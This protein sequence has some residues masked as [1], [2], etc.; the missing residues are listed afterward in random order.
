M[1]EKILIVVGDGGE[2]YETWFAR[3]RFEEAGYQ[4]VAA[5]SKRR[6]NLVIHD[7]EP[8]WD[9]YM[10]RPGYSMESDLTFK[11]VVPGEYAAVLCI[12]GRAPEYLRNDPR[13]LELSS[14]DVRRRQRA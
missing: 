9:T 5:P 2:S 7:F 11:D 14:N 6:L 1:S 8:G 10:E 13:V 4:V 3:H 12:G